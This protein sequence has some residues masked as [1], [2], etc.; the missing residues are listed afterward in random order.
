[1]A[2]E[3]QSAMTIRSLRI[4]KNV[5]LP[6]AHLEINPPRAL[7]NVPGYRSSNSLQTHPS[8]SE[9]NSTPSWLNYLPRPTLAQLPLA[10]IKPPRPHCR[11][12]P[13]L[14]LFGRSLLLPPTRHQCRSHPA[15][16][17]MRRRLRTASMLLRLLWRRRHT[18]RPHRRWASQLPCGHTPQ[19]MRAIWR[20]RRMIVLSFW[21]T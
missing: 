7:A 6:A 17:C 15:C 21:S 2:S 16:P 1:M 8:F 5:R 11:C 9:T 20:W 10:R 14:Y 19:Q 18:L 12:N 4:L 3:F 13:C